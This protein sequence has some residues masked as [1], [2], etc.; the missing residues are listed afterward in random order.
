M[1]A[2]VRKFGDALAALGTATAQL[3][4]VRKRPIDCQRQRQMTIGVLADE[5][6]DGWSSS[7]AKE[8]LRQSQR[9]APD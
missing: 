7:P 9:K 4:I 5:K 8:K 1:G 6:V 2:D 3:L